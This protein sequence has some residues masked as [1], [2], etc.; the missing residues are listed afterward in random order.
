LDDEEKTED[1]NN[2]PNTNTEIAEGTYT[3]NRIRYTN[4]TYCTGKFTFSF[5]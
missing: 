5:I 2:E 3:P 1:Q 4:I